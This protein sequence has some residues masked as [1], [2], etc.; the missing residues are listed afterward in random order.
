MA[1]LYRVVYETKGPQHSMSVM[2]SAT[3]EANAIAAAKAADKNF[4]SPITTTQQAQNIIS[5]S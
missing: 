3:T 1:H 2:V 4:I 5:G